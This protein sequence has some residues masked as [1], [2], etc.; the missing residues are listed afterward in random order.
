MRNLAS[1]IDHTLLKATATPD[2]IRDLCEEAAMYG[3]AAVCVNSVYV[4]LAAHLLA[5]SGV[6][7]ATVVG[8]PLGANLTWVKEEETRQAVRCKAD[9]IDM[10][11][12]LGAA[13]SGQWDGVANDVHSVVEAAEGKIVKAILETCFLDDDEKCQAALA[14]LRGGAHFVKTSTGF[15]SGGATVEDIQLLRRTVGD[16]AQIKASGGIR[17]LEQVRAMIAAGADRIGASAG[18]AIMQA[19]QKESS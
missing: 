17:T 3:F 8:F 7:V 9:E 10:V 14:A 5:G 18:V 2:D 4:D 13:K 6:K 15:G 11:I 16:A 19:L 12:S 1:Y